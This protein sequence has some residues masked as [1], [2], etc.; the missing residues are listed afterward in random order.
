MVGMPVEQR[1]DGV[2]VVA[3]DTLVEGSLNVVVLRRELKL[4]LPSAC[5]KEGGSDVT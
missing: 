1:I 3:C 4:E 5:F 2:G